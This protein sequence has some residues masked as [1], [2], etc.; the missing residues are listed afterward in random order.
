MPEG[1]RLTPY[2]PTAATVV[3]DPQELNGARLAPYRALAC[4]RR[5]AHAAS[6]SI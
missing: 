4:R 5:G 2:W 1:R 6:V 3:D